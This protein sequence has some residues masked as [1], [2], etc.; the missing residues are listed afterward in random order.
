MQRLFALLILL[1]WANQSLASMQIDSS[2]APNP[3]FVEERFVLT[4]SVDANADKLEL[5]RDALLRQ[6]LVVGATNVSRNYQIINGDSRRQTTW[7]TEIYARKAGTYTLPAASVDGVKG[8]PVTIDV[9][10]IPKQTGPARD[11]FIDA[12]LSSTTAYLGQQISYSVKLYLGEE[13]RNG[14]LADPQMADAAIRNIGSDT[15]T[16]EIVDGR[17]YQVIQR[18]FAVVPEQAGSYE[19]IGANVKG[20]LVK[21]NSRGQLYG[22]PVNESAP[23]LTLQVKAAPENYSG[24]WLPSELVTLHDE[25]QPQNSQLTVGEPITRTI[26]LSAIGIEDKQLPNLQ[27]QYPATVKVY[28]DKAINDTYVQEDRL[29][30][31]RVESVALI[32]T[33][34]GEL[35]FPA[36]SVSWWDTAQNR[37]RTAELPART[38]T[39]IA[40]E[41]QVPLAENTRQ[42]SPVQVE[43]DS[44]WFWPFILMSILWLVTLTA[45]IYGYLK[46][47]KSTPQAQIQPASAKNLSFAEL[48]KVC[49]TAQ[50]AAIQQGLQRWCLS[51]GWR[52]RRQ[53]L[54]SVSAT[55]AIQI[56]NQ[57]TSLDKA[58]NQQAETWPAE[59][60]LAAIKSSYMQTVPAN[61]TSLPPLYPTA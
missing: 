24:H 21:Q 43:Q 25:W 31:Q 19:I 7:R 57:L 48:E 26:T 20:Q 13:L 45:A 59:P 41:G 2:V 16:T 30:A 34:A 42:A 1:L 44:T 10:P 12:E 29:I 33:Q 40:A 3:V 49:T 58:V 23:T 60:L 39:V 47:S 51:Q 9:R 54:A 18:N 5:D 22:L 15:K 32:P 35:T 8:K 37:Q 6:G 38:F 11:L 52:S 61:G 4:I 46:R 50:P 55:N 56:E 53:W 14:S 28:P 36:L 27:I 17:R